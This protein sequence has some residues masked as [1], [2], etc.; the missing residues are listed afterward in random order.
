MVNANAPLLDVTFANP[1]VT[2][3]PVISHDRH[4]H[5]RERAGLFE[6]ADRDPHDQRRELGDAASDGDHSRRVDLG[7]LHDR[8]PA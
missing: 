8:H 3:G 7:K 1:V 5:D 4:R 6:S 2:A